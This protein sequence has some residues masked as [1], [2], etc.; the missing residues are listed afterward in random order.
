MR[1]WLLESRR[2][3]HSRPAASR[4]PRRPRLSLPSQFFLAH[5]R[6]SRSTA[7]SSALRSGALEIAGV[8]SR[9]QLRS[10]RQERRRDSW[11]WICEVII[12]SSAA[13][14][15]MKSWIA[16]RMT[17]YQAVRAA[18]LSNRFLLQAVALG[19]TFRPGGAPAAT[20]TTAAQD[21]EGPCCINWRETC[22]S[23]RSYAPQTRCSPA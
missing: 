8:G 6:C 5:R 2:A 10:R 15:A 18:T 21:G 19:V 9:Q 4:Q 23:P 17:G 7:R 20:K 11:S 16:A 14:R 12:S 22:A 1:Y 3:Q 13:V